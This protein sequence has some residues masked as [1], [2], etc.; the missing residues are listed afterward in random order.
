MIQTFERIYTLLNN[1][2]IIYWTKEN[3]TNQLFMVLRGYFGF[4]ELKNPVELN[5]FSELV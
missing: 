5:L 1:S 2:W 4:L 3:I